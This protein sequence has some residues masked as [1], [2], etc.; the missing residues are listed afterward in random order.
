M[1]VANRIYPFIHLS[2]AARWPTADDPLSPPL[3]CYLAADVSQW[4]FSLQLVSFCVF[5][6]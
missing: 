5:P 4:P 1:K 3:Y 6:V 2:V